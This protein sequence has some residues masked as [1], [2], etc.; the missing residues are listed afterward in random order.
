MPS[1][2]EAIPS[3]VA[4][5]NTHYSLLLS[6][7][8]ISEVIS[9]SVQLTMTCKR[10][11]FSLVEVTKEQ[12]DVCERVGRAWPMSS[13]HQIK[14]RRAQDATLQGTTG[15]HGRLH[16]ATEFYYLLC[17]QAGCTRTHR[18]GK[19]WRNTKRYGATRWTAPRQ[20]GDTSSFF[21]MIFRFHIWHSFMYTMYKGVCSAGRWQS[22]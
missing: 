7:L 3:A 16:R 11:H 1:A 5:Q 19:W 12:N 4:A 21:F 17:F 6:A 8:F 18:A 14:R 9:K 2:D 22:V 15:R 13:T 10:V 20:S